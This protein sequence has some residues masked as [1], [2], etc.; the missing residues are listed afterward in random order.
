MMKRLKRAK[1]IFAAAGAAVL[2]TAALSVATPIAAHALPNNCNAWV[3]T[4]GRGYA[5]CTGGTGYYKAG[6][7]CK[8]IGPFGHYGY[9][10]TAEGEWARVGGMYMSVA[11][12]PLGTSNWSP[13]GS[14]VYNAWINRTAETI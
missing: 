2:L 7:A 11:K 6:I 13:T 1:R 4:D 8:P 3:G 10:F 14:G 9:G 12:C 5:K